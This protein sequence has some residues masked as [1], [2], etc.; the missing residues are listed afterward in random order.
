MKKEETVK[1][2][3]V[4][5]G[6]P[7]PTISWSINGRDLTVKDGVQI[8]KDIPNNKY[9]LTIPKTNPT[10]HSGIISIKATNAIGTSQHDISLNILGKLKMD[11]T[12]LN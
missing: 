3:F 11:I 9:S 2:E 6:L 4:V 5:E 10:L 1:F 7:K 12:K 8:E